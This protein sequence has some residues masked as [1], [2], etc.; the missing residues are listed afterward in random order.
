MRRPCYIAIIVMKRSNIL[1]WYVDYAVTFARINLLKK[2]HN[3]FDSYSRS[4]AI[5]AIVRTLVV[6]ICNDSVHI[7][8]T[9]EVSQD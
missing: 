2:Q 6:T 8:E 7:A 1:L 5:W 3:N 4:R 9:N